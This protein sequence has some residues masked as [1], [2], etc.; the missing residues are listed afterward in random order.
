[1]RRKKT[2]V[3]QS[4]SPAADRLAE[5][6]RAEKAF[7]YHVD[8]PDKEFSYVKLSIYGAPETNELF[9]KLTNGRVTFVEAVKSGLLYPAMADRI[10]GMDVLDSQVA[11]NL[12]DAMWKKHK[13]TLVLRRTPPIPAP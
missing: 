3:N 8:L 6:L 1:M 13:S 2:D 11:F 4:E 12:A 7:P 5:L 9:V 10:F